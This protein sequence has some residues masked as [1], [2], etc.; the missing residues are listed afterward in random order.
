MH[1]LPELISVFRAIDGVPDLCQ[2]H[3]RPKIAVEMPFSHNP[4]E[5]W[6]E[7]LVRAHMFSPPCEGHRDIAAKRH[8]AIHDSEF[9]LNAIFYRI[10]LPHNYFNCTP[11]RV[12]T[13][14]PV[15]LM[16]C[17]SEKCRDVSS[18]SEIIATDSMS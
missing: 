18:K 8:I 9:W 14:S 17:K 13:P 11:N 3:R 5:P 2:S 16:F 6:T 4:S 10:R 12:W 1:Q 7:R 15:L